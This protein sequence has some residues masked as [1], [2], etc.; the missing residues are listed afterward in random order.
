MSPFSSFSV[1]FHYT[2]SF[3]Y[4]D[5]NMLLGFKC[6][7]C[8][9]SDLYNAEPCSLY[10][11]VL[12]CANSV[13]LFRLCACYFI[14]KSVVL[15][16]YVRDTWWCACLYSCQ[17]IFCTCALHFCFIAMAMCYR[18]IAQ[19]AVYHKNRTEK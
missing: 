15:H 2:K 16:T 6:F 18:T 17:L 11:V 19:C 5:I 8:I 1:L 14:H 7:E 10:C 12:N 4:S 9:C 13:F 3:G